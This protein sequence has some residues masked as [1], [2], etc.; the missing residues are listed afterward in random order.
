MA[1]DK[2]KPTIVS[3]TPIDQKCMECGT[4]Y[5]AS[6]VVYSN[7]RENITPKR[8]EIC[9]T[10]HLTNL[11]VN[12]ALVANDHIGNLKLRLTVAEREAIIE[13]LTNSLNTVYERFQ[14]TTAVKSGFDIGKVKEPSESKKA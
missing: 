14:G 10:R 7:G 9:Q 6:K 12:K 3:S 2:V 4:G 8:C 5:A 1:K 11:R 13:A